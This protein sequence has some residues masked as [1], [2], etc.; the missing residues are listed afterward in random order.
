MLQRG[1]EGNHKVKPGFLI[2]SVPFPQLSS[3]YF[4]LATPRGGGRLSESHKTVS[5]YWLKTSVY[6]HVS[7]VLQIDSNTT[8]KSCT[9]VFSDGIEIKISRFG[10]LHELPWHQRHLFL[11][12]DYQKHKRSKHKSSLSYIFQKE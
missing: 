10:A 8:N 12:R 2:S 9:A 7:A 5:E 4:E 3:T 1:V 6:N 11:G